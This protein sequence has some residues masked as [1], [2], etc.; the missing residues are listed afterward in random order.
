MSRWL[1]ICL[2]ATGCRQIWGLSDTPD[3]IIDAPALAVDVP[4][5]FG[6]EL[7]CFGSLLG[8]HY[9]FVVMPTEPIVFGAATTI[10]TDVDARCDATSGEVCLIVAT[11]IE[12]SG[13]VTAT[14]HRPLALLATNA[15]TFTGSIDV[16]SH[17]ASALVGAGGNNGDCKTNERN[18]NGGGAGG[19]LAGKGGQGG[20]GSDLGGTPG[21][22]VPITTLRGGCPGGTGHGNNLGVGGNGGG[23]VYLVAGSRITLAGRIDASGAGG[24]GGPPFQTGGGGG[25]SGGV[26]AIDAPTI[27][28]GIGVTLIANGGGGGGGA[29][30]L[31][32]GSDGNDPTSTDA[33]QGGNA[34][35]NAGKGGRGSSGAE[36]DGIGGGIGSFSGGGGGGGA[37]LILSTSAITSTS[38]SPPLTL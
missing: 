7:Q 18:G 27:D 35:N 13:A 34:G 8:Q 1:V 21:L 37:G 14:G 31:V 10:D 3:K 9:C 25:G 38:I 2:M 26:I 20:A 28:A 6:D 11:D 30:S 22:V 33:A 12:L 16:S 5:T 17:V 36:L 23:A 15:I 19:T 29:S 4:Q 32:A 24:R